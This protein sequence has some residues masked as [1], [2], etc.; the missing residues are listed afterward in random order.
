MGHEGVPVKVTSVQNPADL[1]PVN[2][3]RVHTCT[4]AHVHT[5]SLSHLDGSNRTKSEKREQEGRRG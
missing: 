2:P 5:E 3:Q 1:Q 4:R